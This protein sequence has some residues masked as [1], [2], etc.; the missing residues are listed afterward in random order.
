MDISSTKGWT[1]QAICREI[2]EIPTSRYM[3]QDL[4]GVFEMVEMFRS[5][6][7]QSA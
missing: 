2:P 3:L 4:P 5:E 6:D 1:L 7:I